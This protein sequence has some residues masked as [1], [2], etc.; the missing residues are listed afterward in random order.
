MP[1]NKPR[2]FTSS[3]FVIEGRENEI[4]ET[5]RTGAANSF[6]GSDYMIEW[7]SKLTPQQMNDLIEYLK[8]FQSPGHAE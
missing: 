4:Y 5:I 1:G 6:H 2:D 8:T 7:G 3:D